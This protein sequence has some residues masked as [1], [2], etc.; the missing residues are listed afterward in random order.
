[1][2]RLNEPKTSAPRVNQNIAVISAA[3]SYIKQYALI[4]PKILHFIYR[5]FRPILG[6]RC[7]R[8]VPSCS[9]YAVNAL[10]KHGLRAGFTLTVK[11][12]LKCHPWNPGGWDPIP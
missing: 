3:S 5:L 11:R 8:F 12:L 6:P 7:C 2:R 9:E 1:M 4:L 10:E